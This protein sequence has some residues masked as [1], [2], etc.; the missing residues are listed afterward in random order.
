[1][2][3]VLAEANTEKE[4]GME[5]IVGKP[6]I[7]EE[8]NKLFK[9]DKHDYGTVFTY[10]NTIYNPLGK[11]IP[12][13]LYAHEEMHADQQEHN[14]T[15]AKI[16]WKRYIEDPEFRLEQEAEA[17]GRQYAFLCLGT[18]NRDKRAHM[19]WRLA[20]ALS[21]PMY[22]SICTQSMAMRKIKEYA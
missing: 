4:K 21:G 2:N 18:K 7:W 15:I 10:G 1:M 8:A 20:Q 12:M 22:G 17:Y 19:L 3:G 16:W 9:L 14:D 13:D 11:E 6:P 5:M